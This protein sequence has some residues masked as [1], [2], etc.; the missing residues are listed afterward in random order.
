M[1]F[2]CT[3][4]DLSKSLAIAGHALSSRATLPILSC[5]HL[6]AEPDR[7]VLNATNLEIGI[8]C[9]LPAT[10]EETGSLA[11]PARLLTEFVNSL[12][13]G[14]VIITVPEGE[15]TA[16]ITGQRSRAHIRG[17]DPTEYP[18]VFRELEA[19][20]LYCFEAAH[21]KEA[22]SQ[23]AFAAANDDSRPVLTALLLHG[24]EG[25]V[26]F[27]AADAF[28][29]AVRNVP[30]IVASDNDQPPNDILVP[31]RTLIELARILPPDGQVTLS[32]AR[33]GSQACFQTEH[34]TLLTRLLEGQFPSYAS[35]IP[36]TYET[37][38]LIEADEFRAALKA[39][40]PFARDAA[41]I[42][43][44]HLAPGNEQAA[45]TL[46]IEASSDDLGDTVSTL[47][48]S[49]EGAGLTFIFNAT[50]LQNILAAI[51]TSEVALSGLA[52]N[53]PGVFKPVG[54]VEAT[55]VVMPMHTNR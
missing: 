29:L 7:L 1:K 12:P 25:H 21:L 17:M 6:V 55:Y 43:R 37:R 54:D 31:A 41:N 23:V 28:R 50:Y 20:P 40:V 34:L 24:S 48:A 4:A 22:I 42:T 13:D 45:G 15:T 36:T 16:L 35:L 46:T 26:T 38:A 10:V 11:L 9:D 27:A 49:V 30:L 52:T 5:L 19:A 18:Q 47:E 51:P 3:H 39:V 33:N 44:L 14:E 2:T 53:K 8:S 32:V